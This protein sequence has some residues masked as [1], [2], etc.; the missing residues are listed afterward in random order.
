MSTTRRTPSMGPAA[1]TGGQVMRSLRRKVE[2]SLKQGSDE[3][4]SGM[5]IA[6]RRQ[7]TSCDGLLRWRPTQTHRH[8]SAAAAARAGRAPPGSWR[9]KPRASARLSHLKGQIG[10]KGYRSLQLATARGR[11]FNGP[12]RR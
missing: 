8:A 12:P 3:A 6:L 9:S 2:T 7:A 10:R 11:R 4:E 5:T 1:L